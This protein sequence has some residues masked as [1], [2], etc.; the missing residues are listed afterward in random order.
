MSIRILIVEDD[1]A[2]GKMVATYLTKKE[3]NVTSCATA[4]D[5]RDALAN[6][7]FDLLITDLKLP[8]ESGLRLL[9]YAKEIAPLTDVIL[10]TGYADVTTAVEAIKKGALEYIS[11]PFR[12]EELLMIIE[13][14]LDAT[15]KSTAQSS[16]IPNP[17][18]AYI[19]FKLSTPNES[20][21]LEIFD[22]LGKRV[23]AQ[24][25]FDQEKIDT[26]NLNTGFYFYTLTSEH[27]TTTGKLVKN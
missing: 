19:S 15:S 14:S 3:Y 26:Q 9:E 16:A 8:D 24:T 4:K 17:F 10:M 22:A 20:S 25:V 7:T 2:F 21:F 6:Q 5:A 18:S 1:I 23:L 11:K 12:P 13:E 27:N